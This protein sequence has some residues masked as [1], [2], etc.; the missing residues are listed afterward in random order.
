MS[1][2]ID[3]PVIVTDIRSE[4]VHFVGC[5]LKGKIWFATPIWTLNATLENAICCH[6][7]FETELNIAYLVTGHKTDIRKFID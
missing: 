4:I 7:G 6:Q 2:S 5:F 3:L 1:A